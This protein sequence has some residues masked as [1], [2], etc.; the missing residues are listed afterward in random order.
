MSFGV[1]EL[2][3]F[4]NQRENRPVREQIVAQ[5]RDIA[6]VYAL[7]VEARERAK[8]SGEPLPQHKLRRNPNHEFE[9]DPLRFMEERLRVTLTP[10]VI[11]LVNAVWEYQNVEAKSGNAVG[12]THGAAHIIVAFFLIFDD[13]QVYLA[14]APPET[15]LKLL[16]WGEVSKIILSHPELFPS[17]EFKVSLAGMRI[18]RKSDPNSFIQGLAIPVSGDPS[19][20]IARFS[21]KHAPHLLFALDE[22]DAI[23][24]EIFTAIESCMS[25][26][27]SRLLMMFNPRQESGP[28]HQM[29]RKNQCFVVQLRVF[30]H[31][32]VVT[33]RDVIPGAVDREKTVRRI[34]MWTRP[35][36]PGEVPDTECFEV[37]EFLVGAVALDPQRNPYPPLPAGH[38]KIHEPS[39][40]YMVLGDY[41]AISELQLISRAWVDAAQMRYRSYVATYG[42]LPPRNV[43]PLAGQDVAEFGTDLNALAF[44]YGGYVP[45]I[46]VWN[47]VD[48]VESGQKSA[49]ECLN[50]NAS[51]LYIDANGVGAGTPR[52]A[53]DAGFRRAHRV[54]VTNAAPLD[55]DD[56]D[57]EVQCSLVRDLLAWRLRE[58]LRLDKG[59]MLPDDDLLRDE[60]LAFMYHKDNRDRIKVSDSAT[61][62]EKLTRSP[63]RF[64]A[65]ALTFADELENDLGEITA[66]SYVGHALKGE[67]VGLNMEG[68]ISPRGRPIS[69]NGGGRSSGG[70]NG[71][72]L[73]GAGNGKGGRY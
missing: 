38:R 11:E 5:V 32:N 49:Q 26:G 57:C 52:A 65:L 71:H 63:D 68:G 3:A 36:V 27:F 34:N 66:R 69:E 45:P 42:E 19:K 25:G 20:R 16:L 33:G 12:K 67:R 6:M 7:E 1:Q 2:K 72:A 8:A 73:V 61:L 70:R 39:F 10:D 21:G 30:N 43:N 55:P 14:A 41:P 15:N 23:P 18:E 13:A 22:A 51:D 29:E 44:R 46:K 37:P 54:M 28:V 4:R 48:P 24:P 50:R 58:W 60:L 47:N 56:K 64:W 40:Y 9:A 59:A 62:R 35:L 53:R 31:P 17:S